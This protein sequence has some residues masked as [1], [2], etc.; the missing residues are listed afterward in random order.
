MSESTTDQKGQ[1]SG[2]G[3]R[4]VG[5]GDPEFLELINKFLKKAQDEGDRA[6]I[7]R[8]QVEYPFMHEQALYAKQL[9]KQ[10]LKQRTAGRIGG[11]ASHAAR[12]PSTFKAKIESHLKTLTIDQLKKRGLSAC[13]ATDP[14]F[15]EID[16]KYIQE[17]VREFKKQ[18]VNGNATP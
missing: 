14:R 10:I 18:V 3:V 8:Y 2:L 11:K 7:R 13:I 17:I 15:E 4:E 12:Y 9:D 1:L 5:P 16:L 6:G